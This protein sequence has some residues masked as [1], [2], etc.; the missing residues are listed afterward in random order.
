MWITA[1]D[2]FDN[3]QEGDTFE[4]PDSQAEKLIRKGLARKANPEH[5][6][7]MA[8]EGQNK[9]NPTRGAGKAP[10]LPS[11]QAGQASPQQTVDEYPG[12]G[13]VIPDP[14]IAA[15]E[16]AEAQALAE[17]QA[18]DQ[19]AA[20]SSAGPTSVEAVQPPPTKGQAKAEPAEPVA[21]A[22]ASA[23]PRAPRKAPAKQ[24]PRKTPTRRG[25]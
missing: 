22:T 23:T 14:A 25:G 1:L 21:G 13:L 11:S 18:A 8:A 16:A 4:C 10:T 6:N 5:V 2:T 24:S 15:A 17:K 20:Q 19:E 12:G 9:A 7:K 3:R